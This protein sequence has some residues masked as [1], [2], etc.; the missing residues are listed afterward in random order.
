M[1]GYIFRSTDSGANWSQ[2][3]LYD[4]IAPS[5]WVVGCG[6]STLY[7]IDILGSSSSPWALTTGYA[8]LALKQRTDSNGAVDLDPCLCATVSQT[9][10]SLRWVEQDVEGDS[11][12]PNEEQPAF[13]TVARVESDKAVLAGAFGRILTYDESP[14]TMENVVKDRATKYHNRLRDGV[15]INHGADND[16]TNDK[17]FVVGQGWTYWETSDGGTSWTRPSSY[18]WTLSSGNWANGIDIGS[19]G[20]KAA[21]VGTAGFVAK[22]VLSSGTWTWAKLSGSDIPSSLPDL[23]AIAFVTGSNSD[24]FAVGNVGA[25]IKSTDGGATW[26]SATSTGSDTLHGVS[27]LSSSTGLVCGANGKIF[28]TTNGGANW[29]TMNTITLSGGAE[30]RTFYDVYA[31][32]ASGGD[33]IAAMAVGAGGIVYK[34]D[35]A[36]TRFSQVDHD[37]GVTD[38]LLDVEILSSGATV[39]IGGANGAMLFRDSGSWAA[40]KSET[41]FPIFK[42]AFHDADRGFG[43]GSNFVVLRHH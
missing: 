31:W 13:Y 23:N 37:T 3:K 27:F 32:S 4:M 12:D 42:V 20:D 2:S 41:T 40:K 35:A 36:D 10:S 7:G 33:G 26:T 15:F 38:D 11:N 29:T 18:P 16:L 17:G 25:C 24:A 19:G 22:G 43:I 21:I 14:P 1:N 28:K 8:Q 6:L 39:R 9:T 5:A 34:K 30:T